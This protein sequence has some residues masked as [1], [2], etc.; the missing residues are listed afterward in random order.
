MSPPVVKEGG[1]VADGVLGP[2]RE[3]LLK[4]FLVL[5][6]LKNINRVP[7]DCLK[8]CGTV[9]SHLH[10]Q[11]RV[12]IAV[13]VLMLLIDLVRHVEVIGDLR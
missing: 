5:S 6:R 9:R 12:Y 2:P 4:Q 8:C 3:G 13:H 10:G 11:R 7:G 1:G